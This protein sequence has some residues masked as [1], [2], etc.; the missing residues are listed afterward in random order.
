MSYT[1]RM[2]IVCA[3]AKKQAYALVIED[4]AKT[5]APGGVR[6]AFPG[7]GEKIIDGG[8]PFRTASRELTEETGC[9]VKTA[10]QIG[11]ISYSSEARGSHTVY[12]Y[13]TSLPYDEVSEI[14]D[15]IQCGELAKREEKILA[16]LVPLPIQ[17]RDFLGTQ[18]EELR[19]IDPRFHSELFQ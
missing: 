17:V 1:A 11:H 5:C 2:I 14:L 3:D 15:K 18:S 6:M 4:L 8:D 19:N 10:K 9:S 7:G 16:D 12:Y 13:A